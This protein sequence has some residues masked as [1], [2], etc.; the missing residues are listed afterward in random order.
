MGV[1]EDSK[2]KAKVEMPEFSA[3]GRLVVTCLRSYDARMLVSP[4]SSWRSQRKLRKVK[5]PVYIFMN[6]EATSPLDWEL[7][8]A[9]G[10]MYPNRKCLLVGKDRDQ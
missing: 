1:L 4:N 9:A 8:E 7:V 6:C 2:P 10:S 5:T 3:L